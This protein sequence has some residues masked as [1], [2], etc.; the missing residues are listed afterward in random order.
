[1]KRQNNCVLV[2]CVLELSSCFEYFDDDAAG[3]NIALRTLE[4]NMKKEVCEVIDYFLSFLIKYDE[5]RAHNLL[6]LMLDLK[7]KS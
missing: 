2:Y 7:F 3:L 6:S 4:M 1:L 5:K